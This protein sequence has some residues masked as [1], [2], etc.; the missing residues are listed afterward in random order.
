MNS[1]TPEGIGTRCSQW[2][3]SLPSCTWTRIR[4]WLDHSHSDP[5]DRTRRGSR[6]NLLGS[7]SDRATRAPRSLS[8]AMEPARKST[9]LT[10]SANARAGPRPVRYD[11]VIYVRCR[12]PRF[13]V[14][15]HRAVT[16]ASSLTQISRFEL[17]GTSESPNRFIVMCDHPLKCPHRSP[18]STPQA[19]PW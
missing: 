5:A 6:S 19:H 13:D 3:C 12:I 2:V 1:R 7:E 15:E 16:Q 17:S 10:R 4:K 14:A 11:D 8:T 18:L 9:S